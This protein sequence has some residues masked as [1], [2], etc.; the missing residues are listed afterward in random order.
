MASPC[1]VPS[2]SNILYNSVTVT[3]NYTTTVVGTTT[4]TR[5]HTTTTVLTTSYPVPITVSK[6]S[7][8]GGDLGVT[9]GPVVSR[10]PINV[11]D[12]SLQ[13]PEPTTTSQIIKKRTNDRCVVST[14]T[15]WYTTT[16]VTTLVQ[17]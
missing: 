16:H 10:G 15:I 3:H 8:P 6:C 9:V 5:D 2:K 13:L 12:I 17:K 14:T 1:F 11:D 4:A 7:L